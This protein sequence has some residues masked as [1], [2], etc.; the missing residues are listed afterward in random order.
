[1]NDHLLIMY[2]KYISPINKLNKYYQNR[3]T[4]IKQIKKITY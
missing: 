4:L 2:W 3:K 1:M